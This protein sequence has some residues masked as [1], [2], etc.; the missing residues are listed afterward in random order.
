MYNQSHTRIKRGKRK[1]T[2]THLQTHTHIHTYIHTYRND[3]N[4][5]HAHYLCFFGAFKF[6]EACF[7]NIFC[8]KKKLDLKP[9]NKIQFATK[10]I[11]KK[12]FKKRIR[13]C[14]YMF[15]YDSSWSTY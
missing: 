13:V 3:C 5:T 15:V 12:D 11:I 10:E 8:C 6:V 7:V 1:Y 4:H 2:Y 14:V 9:K